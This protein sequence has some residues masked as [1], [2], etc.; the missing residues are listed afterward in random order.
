MNVLGDGD[1]AAQGE[2]EGATLSSSQQE[3][4]HPPG[5]G[6][7]GGCGSPATAGTLWSHQHPMARWK[8]TE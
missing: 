7:E 2:V 5:E 3:V 8:G 1:M 6:G 4:F